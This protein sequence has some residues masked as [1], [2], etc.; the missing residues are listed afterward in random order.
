MMIVWEEEG[1]IDEGQGHGV[2][3]HF[4][5]SHHEFMVG[6]LHGFDWLKGTPDS[7]R[8]SILAPSP[9]C[10]ADVLSRLKRV[11]EDAVKNKALEQGRID[12][13]FY[14]HFNG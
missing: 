2:D 4:G 6:C 13:E 1:E 10:P 5:T 7:V 12:G 11:I 14:A 9:Q 8:V 3:F